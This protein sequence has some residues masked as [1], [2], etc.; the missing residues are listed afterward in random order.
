MPK[1]SRILYCHCSNTELV[2]AEA[3]AAV[4]ETLAEA[5]LEFEAVPDLCELAAKGD[6]ALARLAQGGPLR[7]IA[8]Y[9]RTVRWLFAAAGAPLPEKGVEILNLRADGAKKIVAKFRPKKTASKKGKKPAAAALLKDLDGAARQLGEWIPWFPVI[10][11][12]RCKNCKQCLNFCLFGVYTTA[13][14]G[15]V[16]VEHPENCKTGCPACARVCP[17]LAIIFPKHG[18]TPVNGAEVSE[19]DL[20]RGD[21]RVGL[22]AHSRA[23]ILAALRERNK[24]LASGDASK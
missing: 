23:D 20:A 18:G 10:D 24:A 6:A 11:R 12:C 2:P 5:G 14:N 1:K 19:K 9:P 21:M 7:L 16:R 15:T 8:C 3:K 22:Q 17:H 4:L 13:A